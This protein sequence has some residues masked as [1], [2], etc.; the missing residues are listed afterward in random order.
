M[1]EFRAVAKD[2]CLFEAFARHLFET[3]DRVKLIV[4]GRKS[5]FD[6]V[7]RCELDR[8]GSVRLQHAVSRWRGLVAA[9]EEGFYS[10][11]AEEITECLPVAGGVALLDSVGLAGVGLEFNFDG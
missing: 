6:G 10:A 4:F 3:I 11:F 2:E 9:M 7:M 8:G 1:R 5:N